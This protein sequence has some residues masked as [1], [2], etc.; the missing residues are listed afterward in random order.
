MNERKKSNILIVDDRPENILSLEALLDAPDMNIIKAYSGNEALGMILEYDFALVLL[1][2]QMPEMDGFETAELMRSNTRTKHIPIIFVTAI[3][4]DQQHVF[5][6]YQAGAVDY[7]FKPLEPEILKNKVNVFLELHSQK[8]ALKNN[9]DELRKANQIIHDQQ[10]A[11]IEEE[12][13]KVLLQMAGATAHELN[14][15]LMVLLGNIDLLEMEIAGDIPQQLKKILVRI[16]EAG[17]RISDTVKKI[18][19]LRRVELKPYA[20]QSQIINFD[21]DMN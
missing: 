8:A 5:K 2:V 7:I 17:Q 16:K 19:T 13:L 18:Q 1:D 14:Q 4:K 10:K 3:N 21:Q 9:N 20:N 11:A 12:R 6:G 15:P